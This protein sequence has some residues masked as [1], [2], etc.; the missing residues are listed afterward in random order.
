MRETETDLEAGDVRVEGVLAL[1]DLWNG[2]HGP[3]ELRPQL[4]ASQTPA[5]HD[6]TG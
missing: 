4:R 5:T 6:D 2:E 3:V 1:T